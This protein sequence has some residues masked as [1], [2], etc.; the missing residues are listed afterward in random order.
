[1]PEEAFADLWATLKKG[2]TVDRVGQ[3]PL[4]ERRPLLGRGERHADPRDGHLTGYLSV[5]SKPGRTQVEGAAR[6]YEEMK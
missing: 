6:L 2:K 1:M 3:E 5:R 4:Q